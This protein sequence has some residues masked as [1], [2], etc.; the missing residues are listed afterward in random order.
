MSASTLLLLWSLCSPQI[1][2]L[3]HFKMHLP[4]GTLDFF[5]R[6][7]SQLSNALVKHQVKFLVTFLRHVV[8]EKVIY[9]ARIGCH[10]ECVQIQYPLCNAKD[11][12]FLKKFEQYFSTFVDGGF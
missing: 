9:L 1:E 12:N 8:F 6:Y 5:F 3:V 2:E 4:V 10:L 7:H 11:H